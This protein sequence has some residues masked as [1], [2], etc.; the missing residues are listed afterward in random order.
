MYCIHIIIKFRLVIFK[1]SFSIVIKPE[2]AMAYIIISL[3]TKPKQTSC[4][5]YIF[6]IIIFVLFGGIVVVCLFV[7]L[8]YLQFNN[9][10][11]VMRGLKGNCMRTFILFYKK[12]QFFSPK[13]QGMEFLLMFF[14]IKICQTVNI[15]MVS[16]HR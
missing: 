11:N 14:C 2:S 10:L 5:E 13:N 1:V 6:F 8:V 16:R 7:G 3:L 15:A 12:V 9:D 4:S